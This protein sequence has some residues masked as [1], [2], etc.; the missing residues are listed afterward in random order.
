[1][2]CMYV[3]FC[4][5][6]SS[7]SM[8]CFIYHHLE[9]YILL[10]IIIVIWKYVLLYVPLLSEN[11]YCFIIIWKHVLYLAL[12]SESRYYFNYHYLL[13]VCIVLCNIFIWKHIM[14]IWYDHLKACIVLSIIITWKYVLFYL[15][16]S[17]N[18][19]HFLSII[20]IWKQVSNIIIW[21]QI[22]FYLLWLSESL[23]YYNHSKIIYSS[24]YY[25]SQKV[26]LFYVFIPLKSEICCL[27]SM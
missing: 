5:L 19:M 3:I 1:M 12:S 2:I 24:I 16:S 25:H 6:T 13:K 10:S 20:I 7:E 9:A 11:I 23:I 26:L 4:L 15:L 27:K 22:L 21:M 18:R 17:F 14:F 8:Y